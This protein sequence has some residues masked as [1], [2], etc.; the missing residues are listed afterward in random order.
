[1]NMKNWISLIWIG[2]LAICQVSAQ[3][4]FSNVQMKAT[5]VSGK[6]YMLEGAGGNM[7]VSVGEDGVLI[8]DN[9]FAPLAGKI[10]AA[11][12]EL[13]D[14]RIV[15]V[16]NTHH[17]GDHTGGNAEFGKESII[18]AQENVRE[19]LS[20]AVSGQSAKTG[21]PVITFEKSLTLHFND[22]PI[23]VFHLPTGHTDGDSII[24]F[25]KSEVLHMGD[26]FFSG[27]F[28][29][30]DLN[31]GGNV[32]GYLANVKKVLEFLNDEVKIIPGHGALATKDDLEEFQSMLE[33]TI[34]IVR[35]RIR[36][37]YS[38][39]KSKAMGL[40]AKWEV[41]GEHFISTERWIEIV[42]NSLK[43]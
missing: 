11:I 13:S 7:G 5:P 28:P 30:I 8:V 19:R 25:E 37:G 21:L 16:F 12:K 20:A 40:P 36:E 26:L 43:A 41:W 9:Q 14:E 2:G 10:K 42:Y 3:R 4:D 27:R 34:Q 15:Y 6:V 29:F 23:K 35:E 33:Q 1:M 31:S 22:E 32:E 17:H 38:L 39:E 24:Y 18:I